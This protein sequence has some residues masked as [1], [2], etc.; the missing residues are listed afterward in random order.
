MPQLVL[1]IAE[2]LHELFTNC[3]TTA[4]TQC[5]VLCQVVAPTVHSFFVLIVTIRCPEGYPA[6]RFF[7]NKVLEMVFIFKSCDIR[8]SKGFP[9]GVT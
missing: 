5:R 1:P 7:A 3:R 9:T 4:M 8:S 6:A 2:D